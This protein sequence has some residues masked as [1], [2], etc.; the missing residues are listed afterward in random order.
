MC[1]ACGF[2]CCAWNGFSG[3]GCDWCTNPACW[4]DSGEFD[5]QEEDD[6]VRE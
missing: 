2:Q 5:D 4:E 3:C 6:E 1:N